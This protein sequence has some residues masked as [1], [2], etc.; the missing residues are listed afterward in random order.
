MNILQHILEKYNLSDE[1]RPHIEIPNTG[2]LDL[3]KLFHELDFKI[4]AEIGVAAGE[5]SLEICENNPQL[6]KMYGIDPWIPYVGYNDY[7]KE[8][9]FSKLKEG[10][11]TRLS[12]LQ[13]YEFIRELSMDAL[14]KF[15]D[16]SLDFCYIDA[17]HSNPYVTDDIF[18]WAKKVRSGGIISGHDW[19]QPRGQSYKVKEAVSTYVIE[20][21]INP[22]FI[23][24]LKK[25]IPGFVR[26]PSRSWAIVKP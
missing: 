20:N 11:I 16:D 18:G 1:G 14:K 13:H 26:D 24:G 19:Q 3:A 4:G 9:T 5:Y 25:S 10:A 6:T 2:R 17:N 8:S 22:F 7:M 21:K 12:G 15:E 23:F